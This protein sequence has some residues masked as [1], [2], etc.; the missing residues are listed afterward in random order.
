LASRGRGGARGPCQTLLPLPSL[1]SPPP[2]CQPPVNVCHP[3]GLPCMTPRRSDRERYPPV[4]LDVAMATVDATLG[5][6]A[7]D[8][9]SCRHLATH[10]AITPTFN[11]T[12]R[13]GP[14]PIVHAALTEQT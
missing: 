12:G 1:R 4:P 8:T 11:S 3:C 9:L 7:T 6:D 5:Q 14:R 10:L 13:P 2:P